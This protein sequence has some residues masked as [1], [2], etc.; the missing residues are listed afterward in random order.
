MT[1]TTSNESTVSFENPRWSISLAREVEWL[2]LNREDN[3]AVVRLPDGREVN[4][5]V[6]D[7]AAAYRPGTVV[8]G[9]RSSDNQLTQGVVTER[10]ATGLTV[11]TP[12]GSDWYGWDGG[13]AA[14]WSEN[15]SPVIQELVRSFYR[16]HADMLRDE[17]LRTQEIVREHEEWKD[18]LTS[19]AHD[20]ANKHGYC[21]DFDDFMANH[22]LARRQFVYEVEVD[23][24]TT[25]RVTVR[26]MGTDAEDA[27][28]NVGNDDVREAWRN[29]DRTGDWDDEWTAQDAERVD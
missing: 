1:I 14:R 15:V 18:Q 10:S 29:T 17:R 8:S 11:W 28:Q 4:R 13:A 16:H 9:R 27:M 19:D 26:A 3:L 7:L 6:A 12:A 2:R 21:G 23:V 22:G 20:A 5:G 25:V 24:P